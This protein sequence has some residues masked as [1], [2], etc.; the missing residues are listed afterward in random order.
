MGKKQENKTFFPTTPKK[1][2]EDLKESSR[3]IKKV[4]YAAPQ[5]KLR[6]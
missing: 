5:K 4:Y 1:I 2:G 6:G 3:V